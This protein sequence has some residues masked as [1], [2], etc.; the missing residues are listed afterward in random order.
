MDSTLP[1]FDV[2]GIG[3]SPIDIITLVDHYP[4]EREV[5]KALDMVIQGGGPVA[6]AMVTLARLGA[7]TAMVDKLGND[8]R[9][10][11][12]L[13]EFIKEGVDTRYI[14]QQFNCSSSTANVLVT[15]NDGSRAALFLPG[16]VPELS[17]SEF[18]EEIILSAKYLHI[19]GRH[20]DASLKAVKLAHDFDVQV[21]FDGGANRY[22]PELKKLVPLTDV[23]IVAKDFAEKYTSESNCKKAAEILAG[24]GPGIV[25]VT[26]GAEGSWICSCDGKCFHQSAFLS[27]DT[28]DTTGC[29]DS[30]HGAFLFGLLKGLP[31][32]ET[33][34]FASAVASINSQH[35][36][37]RTGLPSLLQV[38]S[39]L[40]GKGIALKLKFR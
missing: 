11:L 31:I 19:N 18:N 35:L 17:A 40:S 4:E 2:I 16:N 30:Y 36:G 26:Q 37:G 33:A 10:K 15:K 38:S 12:I 25:V 6:T 1:H 34:V 14:T 29:G 13:D 32:E 28:I 7:K 39:F 21:S 22:R 8:W 9:G 5:Q 24:C 23:C 20:W 27:A 3:V